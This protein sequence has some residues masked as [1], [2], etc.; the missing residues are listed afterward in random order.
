MS[1]YF[2]G[3]TILITGGASGIGKATALLFA[4]HKA[5]VVIADRDENAAL[6]LQAEIAATGAKSLFIA[7]DVTSSAQVE[8]LLQQT[9]SQFGRLDFAFNNA[10]IEP[11]KPVLCA[12]YS[13]EVWE[14]LLNVNLSG[15][16]RCMKYELAVMAEQKFG[17]IVNN[18]SVLGLVGLKKAA[19]YVASKHG[20]IGLTK[21]AALDYADLGIRVNAVCP[22]FIETPMLS[23]MG[24]YENEKA[25]KALADMHPMRR[26]GKPE[27]IARAVLWLCSDESSFVTGTALEIDGG[28]LAR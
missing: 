9:L 8:N 26:L 22:G 11:E 15:V 4:S 25:Y 13:D 12:D 6:A 24:V 18:A 7:A 23:S 20:V 19:P 10:G 21:T 17:A 1:D 16:W 2:E 27:E 28:Y 14:N 5:L 3:K